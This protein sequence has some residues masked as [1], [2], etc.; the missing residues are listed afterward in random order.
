MKKLLILVLIIGLLM[1]T[2]VMAESGKS[3]QFEYAVI[4]GNNGYY[5]FTNN[6]WVLDH[7]LAYNQMVNIGDVIV[8]YYYVNNV[9]DIYDDEPIFF[10]NLSN[11]K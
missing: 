2:N 4:D 11:Y 9:N 5:Y 8:I 10:Y 1:S 3:I 7:E 6:N